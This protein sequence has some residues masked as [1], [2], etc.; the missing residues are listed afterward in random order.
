MSGDA[1]GTASSESGEG[2]ELIE[3]YLAAV[4]TGLIGPRRWRSEVIAELRDGLAEATRAYATATGAPGAAASAAVAEFGPPRDVA[5]GFREVAAA[6]L[7]RRVAVG[8]LASG[9]VAASAWVAAMG[10]SGIAPWDGGL[11]GPWRLLPGLGAALAVAVPAAMLVLAVTGRTGHRWG[12]TRPRLAPAAAVIATGACAV[13]DVVMLTAVGVWLG[14]TAAPT[15]W[16]V[17]AAAAGFSGIRCLLAGC[18]ARRCLL[19][20][21]RLA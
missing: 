12:S 7:A 18:A 10:A 20:Q 9:P 4:A 5:A 17:L 2:A 19:A 13:G 11:A 15:A 16:P 21:A 8:L 1:V 6:G 14:G 3:S